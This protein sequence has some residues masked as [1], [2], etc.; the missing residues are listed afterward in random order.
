M[1]SKV[2]VFGVARSPGYARHHRVL[3]Q[4]CPEGLEHVHQ[5]TGLLAGKIRPGRIARNASFAVTACEVLRQNFP[6]CRITRG[7]CAWRGL[8]AQ[9]GVV[10]RKVLYV[11]VAER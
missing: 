11:G 9:P 3:A 1:G 7:L 6:C 4:T 8:A 2:S 5:I 10:G